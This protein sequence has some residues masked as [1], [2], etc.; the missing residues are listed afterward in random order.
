VNTES[1]VE[2]CLK[3]AGVRRKIL[4]YR[5]GQVIFSQ[6]DKARSVFYLREGRVKITMNSSDGNVA[7][8]ALLEEGQFFGEGCIARRPFR[9]TTATAIATISVLEIQKTEMIRAIHEAPEFSDLFI[10]HILKRNVRAEENLADQIFNSSENRLARALLSIGKDGK[11]EGAGT[12]VAKVSQETLAEMVGTT[13]SRVSFFMNKFRRLGF[14]R[15]NGGLHINSSCLR[16]F[17]DRVRV[18]KIPDF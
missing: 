6:G 1:D 17:L 4:L 3:T 7:L 5:K 8:I 15:Y 2:K 18:S 13:R 12:L 11:H 9:V 14:I 10:A 16:V